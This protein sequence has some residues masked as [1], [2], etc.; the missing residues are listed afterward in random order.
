MS[1]EKGAQGNGICLE[2]ELRYEQI[3]KKAARVNQAFLRACHTFQLFYKKTEKKLARVQFNHQMHSFK[4]RHIFEQTQFKTYSSGDQCCW[5]ELQTVRLCQFELPSRSFFN[6]FEQK[7]WAYL[8][9]NEIRA[10]KILC[11]AFSSDMRCIQMPF[12]VCLFGGNEIN[13]RGGTI[14]SNPK[15]RYR[16]DPI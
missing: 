11:A 15:K 2:Q 12:V 6:I 1:Y 7:Y 16:F 3:K 5:L 14:G 9:K 10:G 8:Q 4:S 13:E